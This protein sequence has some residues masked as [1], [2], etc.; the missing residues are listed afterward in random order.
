MK[1]RA[2]V[3]EMCVLQHVKGFHT[4]WKLQEGSVAFGVMTLLLRKKKCFLLLQFNGYKAAL[5]L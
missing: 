1:L 4:S 5:L 2:G 3:A